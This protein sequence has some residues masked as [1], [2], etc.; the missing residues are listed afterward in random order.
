M[1]T[2]IFYITAQN[3][4]ST[5]TGCRVDNQS[6][7]SS[8]C[9]HFSFHH[10][11]QINS[12][13]TQWLKWPKHDADNKPPP[14][15]NDNGWRYSS[16]PLYISIYG[17][18]LNTLITLPLWHRLF[19]RHHMQVSKFSFC[20]PKL[21]IPHLLNIPQEIAI[22]YLLRLQSLGNLFCSDVIK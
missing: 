10:H 3:W 4:V 6:L 18:L 9:R 15:V 2:T 17:T 11:V 14:S 12:R 16:S 21:Q 8:R 19:C 13:V 22:Y 5:G 1:K 20:H 7:I